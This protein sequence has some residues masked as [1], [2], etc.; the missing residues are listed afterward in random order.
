ALDYAVIANRLAALEP[1]TIPIGDRVYPSHYAVGFPLLLVPGVLAGL[2]PDRL[3]LLSSVFAVFGVFC[4]YISARRLSNPFS[5]AWAALMLALAPLY[6]RFGVML[7][8]DAPAA[9]LTALWATLLLRGSWGLLGFTS[10]LACSVRLTGV[11]FCFCGAIAALQTRRA[12]R[13]M[14]G[15]VTGFAPT[16]YYVLAG[17]SHLLGGYSFWIPERYRAITATFN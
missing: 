11:V 13:F 16:A 17:F 3:W 15:A 4:T 8:S 14:S 6:V 7:M 12:L 9:V 1:P 2:P 10:A 5:A